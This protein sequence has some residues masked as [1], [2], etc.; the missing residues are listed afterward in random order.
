MNEPMNQMAAA[1]SE[2]QLQQQIDPILA[3][4]VA[5][6]GDLSP[7]GKLK[8]C[9]LNLGL[10]EFVAGFGNTGRP[11]I[12]TRGFPFQF[13]NQLDEAILA[14]AHFLNRILSRMVYKVLTCSR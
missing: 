8:N 14:L 9:L 13:N 4:A 10:K 12:Q 2:E 7:K 11:A 5:I 3:E 1:L 6:A